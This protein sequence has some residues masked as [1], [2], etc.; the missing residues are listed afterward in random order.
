M[1]RPLPGWPFDR[2]RCSSAY[3]GRDEEAV[4]IRRRSDQ[5][6]T[7]KDAK[8]ETPNAPITAPCPTSFS[9]REETEVARLIRELN[10]AQEQQA[11]TSEMLRVINS[12]SGNLEPMFAS[13]LENAVRICDARYGNVYRWDGFAFHLVATHNTPVAF[14]EHANVRLLA[15]VRTTCLGAPWQAKWSSTSPMLVQKIESNLP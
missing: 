2:L 11:A 15:L 1:N 14:A 10:E 12:S 3:G 6:A 4:Q 5:R 13:M 7:S 8:A 9:S